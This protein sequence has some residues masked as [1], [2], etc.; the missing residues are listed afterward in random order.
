LLLS[1]AWFGL[2]WF[3]LVWFGL[4]WF[5]L[6]FETGSHCGALVGLELTI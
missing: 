2:V 4:V 6:V 1:I 3:G 5:G